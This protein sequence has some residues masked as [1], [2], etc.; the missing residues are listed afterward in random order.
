MAQVTSK[1]TMQREMVDTT[2]KI[3]KDGSCIFRKQNMMQRLQLQRK[4]W[5]KIL[6]K[7]DMPMMKE[8]ESTVM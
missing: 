3:V 4:E 7:I 8:M 1:P 6:A 2:T 5:H